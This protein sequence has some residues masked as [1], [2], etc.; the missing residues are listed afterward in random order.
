MAK[1]RELGLPAMMN[2]TG[3]QDLGVAIRNRHWELYGID[4]GEFPFV[5][6]LRTRSSGRVSEG[7]VETDM[8]STIAS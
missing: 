3:A 5:Y 1:L 6:G 8:E 4:S 7:S 2:Q